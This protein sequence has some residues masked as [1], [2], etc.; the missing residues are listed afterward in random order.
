MTHKVEIPEGVWVAISRKV[1]PWLMSVPLDD[2]P[3]YTSSH[4]ILIDF[5]REEHYTEFVLTWL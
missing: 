1:Y 5:E 3:I 4:T 2:V